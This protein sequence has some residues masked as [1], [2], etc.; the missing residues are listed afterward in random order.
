M[1][2]ALT[3]FMKDMLVSEFHEQWKGNYASLEA[4]HGFIQWLFPIHE[5]GMNDEAQV[6]QRHEKEFLQTDAAAQLYLKKSYALM[7][8]FYGFSV[9][10]ATGDVK[11]SAIFAPRFRNLETHFHNNLRITRILKGASPSSFLSWEF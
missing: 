2:K 7:L 8:D 10:I 3:V 9:D 5:R 11:R 4:N 1:L 6:L